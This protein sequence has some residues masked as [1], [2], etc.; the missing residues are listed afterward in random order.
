MALPFETVL[1]GEYGPRGELM[2]LIS[3]YAAM[4]ASVPESELVGPKGRRI[5]PWQK[6]VGL[7]MKICRVLT[8]PKPGME[9]KVE[10]FYKDLADALKTYVA[11]LLEHYGIA[12]I[13]VEEA[14]NKIKGAVTKI[15][16][17]VDAELEDYT[18]KGAS[19]LL[20]RIACVR[21]LVQGL[22]KPIYDHFFG[23]PNVTAEDK[24]KFLALMT[25]LVKIFNDLARKHFGSEVVDDQY[26]AALYRIVMEW[27]PSRRTLRRK[28]AVAAGA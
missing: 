13:N 19:K 17:K 20:A 11:P 5:T 2:E 4:A 23:K 16:E 28:A 27:Q 24:A 14:A 21:A 9:K 1:P 8:V 15:A 22:I 26:I 6:A 3:R 12:G 7:A 25:A 18:G 10:E